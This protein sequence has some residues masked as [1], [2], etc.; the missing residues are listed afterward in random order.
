MIVYLIT[1]WWEE[2]ASNGLPWMVL[3]CLDDYGVP[4]DPVH[5]IAGVHNEVG[6]SGE[7]IEVKSRMMCGNDDCILSGDVFLRP[8]D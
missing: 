3:L 8:L 5:G 7:F 2:V 1:G 4:T 6:M